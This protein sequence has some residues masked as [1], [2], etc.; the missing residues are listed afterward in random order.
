MGVAAAR[1]SLGAVSVW[2]YA[3]NYS[4][5]DHLWGPHAVFPF[6]SFVRALRQDGSY[7]LYALSQSRLWFTVVFHL[8][9]GVAVLFMIGWRSRVMT[10]VHYVFMWS[11]F[12]RNLF[13]LDGGDNLLVLV[14]VYLMFADSGHYFALGARERRERANRP[15]HGLAWRIGTIAHNAAIAAIVAQ[16]CIVYVAAALFKVQGPLWQNGTALYYIMRVQD[17]TWPG[18]SQHF[19]G[20]AWLVA[21]GTYG[22]ILFQAAFPFLLLRRVTRNWAFVGALGMHAGIALFMH[23]LT[24]SWVVVSCELLLLED[25]DFRRAWKRLQRVQPLLRLRIGVRSRPQLTKQAE[26]RPL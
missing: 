4:S 24:F 11:L 25:R 23:L 8:G 14:L 3:E 21:V 6:N 13:I 19:Y 15:S 17:F 2:L 1:L 20:S 5:R 12:H 16:V 7:S 22:T 10:V 26:R 9:M 18:W